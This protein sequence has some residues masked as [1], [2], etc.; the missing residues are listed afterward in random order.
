MRTTALRKTRTVAVLTLALG[1]ICGNAFAFLQADVNK[2]NSTGSCAGC[3]LSGANLSTFNIVSYSSSAKDLS[4]V[5]LSGAILTR[6][7]FS[8]ALMTGANLKNADL[9]AATLN[10]AT[11]RNADLSNANMSTAVMNFATYCNGANLTGAKLPTNIATKKPVF[12]AA[13]WIDGVKICKT[14]SLGVCN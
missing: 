12:S 9:S 8:N 1:L 11:L 6:A 5:N 10:G 3:D 14:P 4:N 13:R 2:L 7:N